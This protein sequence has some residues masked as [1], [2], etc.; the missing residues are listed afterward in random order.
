MVHPSSHQTCIFTVICVNVFLIM[1]LFMAERFNGILGSLHVNNHQIEVQLMRKFLE[2]HQ[3]GSLSWPGEFSGFKEMLSAT[4]KGSLARRLIFL[5]LNIKRVLGLKATLELIFSIYH[6][7]T[8]TL[9]RLSLLTKRFTWLMEVD[10][11]TKMYSF[12]HKE[13]SIVYVPKFTR[14]FSQLKLYDQKLDSRYSRSER[15]GC[16]L[17]RWFG[18]N[19]LDTQSTDVRPGKLCNCTLNIY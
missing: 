4:D 12:L 3:L 8:N 2:Q 9:F 11:L 7:W 18:A 16:I 5:Q 1:V 10:A 13:D 14:Q 15:S 19:G 6:L 17:A